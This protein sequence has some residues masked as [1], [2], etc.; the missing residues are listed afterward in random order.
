MD[1][2]REK[3]RLKQGDTIQEWSSRLNKDRVLEW[4]W[5]DGEVL[6]VV[7]K[8]CRGKY[9]PK[10]VA[11][12]QWHDGNYVTGW[13]AMPQHEWIHKSAMLRRK[14]MSAKRKLGA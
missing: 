2:R 3:E 4:H 13:S 5:R 7:D 9:A 14:P 1:T 11:L 8:P 12:I 10:W 6:A